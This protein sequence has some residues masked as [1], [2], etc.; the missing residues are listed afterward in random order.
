M[1]TALP[2]VTNCFCVG[3]FTADVVVSPDV[4][5]PPPQAAASTGTSSRKR[6][7]RRTTGGRYRREG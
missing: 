7:R 1:Q 5:P 2:A 6:A 3:R 4:E